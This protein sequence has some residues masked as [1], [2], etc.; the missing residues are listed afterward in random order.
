MKPGVKW[1]LVA[2]VAL[3]AA[4][5]GFA[6]NRSSLVPDPESEKAAVQLLGMAF[7]TADGQTKKLADWQG[8]ILVVNFW[9]TWCQPCREEMPEFSRAQDEYG[10]KGVQFVGIAI[11]E[12]A[13]VVEFSKKEPVTYPL[14]IAPAEMPGLIAKLGNQQQ[15]LPFTIIVSRDGKLFSSHLGRLTKENLAKE[16]VPLL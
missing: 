9:A 15:A 7:T 6:I 2:F 10:S 11:D 16:L 8:R 5:A 14:L 13:N 4:W 1:L 12:A 3:I